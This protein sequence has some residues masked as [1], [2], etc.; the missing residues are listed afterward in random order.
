VAKCPTWQWSAGDA[1]NAKTYL[2][3]DKQFLIT[4][5]VPSTHRASSLGAAASEYLMSL[6]AADA[7]TGAGGS[8]A[9]AGPNAGADTDGDWVVTHSAAASSGSGS[10]A[11]ASASG[12]VAAS[13]PAAAAQEAIPDLDDFEFDAPEDG[14][15]ADLITPATAAPAAGLG[16]AAAGGDGADSLR[17][18]AASGGV[19]RVSEPAEATVSVR[20]YDVSVCYDKRYRTPRVFLLGY[21]ARGAPLTAEDVMQDVSSDHA[22]KTVTQDPHPH[23]GVTQLSIHPC[24]HAE[25]MKRLLD[26]MHDAERDAARARLLAQQKDTEKNDAGEDAA[27]FQHLPAGARPARAQMTPAELDKAVEEAAK[28]EFERKM[29]VEKYIFLFMKFIASVVPTIEYDYTISMQL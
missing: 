16:S 7:A 3:K 15:N 14:N 20:T 10:A 17:S 5:N 28:K 4:R 12:S 23:T 1:A 2:P 19:L 22:F 13:K 25:T 18:A 24:R 11:S 9:A 29:P 8:G 26:G 6:D 21:G 27:R